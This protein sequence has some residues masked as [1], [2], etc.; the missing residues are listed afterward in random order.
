MVEIK[1][2]IN[3]W[4]R[5][6]PLIEH[7]QRKSLLKFAEFGRPFKIERRRL[8]V[9]FDLGLRSISQI[10]VAWRKVGVEICEIEYSPHIL[11]ALMEVKIRSTVQNSFA[12][13]KCRE[14]N[15][16]WECGKCKC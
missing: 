1:S 4:R 3:P 5:M 12:N 11:M 14:G 7:E 15:F 10:T 9:A 13:P 16:W 2:E 8:K 6:I